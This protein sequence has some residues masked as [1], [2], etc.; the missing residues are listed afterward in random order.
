VGHVIVYKNFSKASDKKRL[1]SLYVDNGY[2][3]EITFLP[4][5]WKKSHGQYDEAQACRFTA[6][7]LQIARQS[8]VP[9]FFHCTVGEDRTGVLAGLMRVAFDG[10]SIEKA[11]QKEMCERGYEGGNPRKFNESFFVVKAVRE[12]LT[13]LYLKMAA[14]LQSGSMT[15]DDCDSLPSLEEVHLSVDDFQCS[16]V[17]DGE[18]L[19]TKE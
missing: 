7:A 12:N 2:Q 14:K 11:F 8:P 16:P 4:M 6:R 13:P 17:T 3:G 1:Q 19:C 5:E 9:V 18:K 10:W 15:E